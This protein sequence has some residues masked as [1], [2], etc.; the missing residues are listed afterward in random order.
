MQDITL[1]NETVMIFVFGTLL[2]VIGY[3]INMHLKEL[4]KKID[5]IE[6][7]INEDR[8]KLY[9]NINELKER[10]HKIVN[11]HITPLDVRITKLE[12]R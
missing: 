7:V 12:E 5:N 6:K 3:L 2:S 8:D 9:S 11:E 10:Y 4:M 1:Y